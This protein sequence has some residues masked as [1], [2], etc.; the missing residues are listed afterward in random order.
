MSYSFH[1]KNGDMN[2]SGPGGFAIVSGQQKLVQD[3]K[4]WLLEPRGTDASHP[5]YGS[6]I[7][8]GIQPDGSIVQSSIGTTI[9]DERLLDIE[10]E[11]R[12]VLLAYQQQQIDR[13]QKEVVQYNGKNTFSPGEILRSVESVDVAQLD[14]AVIVKITILTSDGQTISF[15]Q[16][17][18]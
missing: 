15:V 2:L 10:T 5:E 12:R 6:I 1:I 9:D 17:V 13:L 14:N 4:N 8:G 7:D 18:V 11:I 3:L 16:P